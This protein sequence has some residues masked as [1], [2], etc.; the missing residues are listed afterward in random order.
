MKRLFLF[1]FTV[2]NTVLLSGMSID[3]EAAKEMATQFMNLKVG[4]DGH[5][6]HAPSRP[7][8]LKLAQKV[9][10]E[11]GDPLYY[12]FNLEENGYVIVSGNDVATPIL[13][14]SDEGSFDMN[15]IP[16][17]LKCLLNNY[18]NQIEFA[19]A[20]GVSK[21][22]QLNSDWD[23]ISPMIETKWNQGGPY[24][25]LCPI[26]PAY[27]KR[28]M[29]G[30]VGV[31]IGQLMYYHKWPKVG[32]GSVSYQWQNQTLS[33]DFSKVIFDW[34]DM[35]LS[36]NNAAYDSN[37]PV[38][39]LLYNC[40][41]AA[42]A[43]FG[44]EETDASYTLETLSDYFGYKDKIK[45]LSLEDTSVDDFEAVVYHEL[46]NSRP[47][48]F[49]AASVLLDSDDNQ[50]VGHAMVI[51]GFEDGYFHINFGWGGN[52]D[53]YFQLAAILVD[54][55]FFNSNQGILYDI[56]P[57]YNKAKPAVHIYPSSSYVL[58]ADGTE[59]I[60]WKGPESDINMT[61][62]DAF[63]NVKC[64]KG[65]AFMDISTVVDVVLPDNTEK[66][67]AKAFENCKELESVFIPQ[68]VIEIETEA[69]SNC[70][71]LDRIV[72]SY[73]STNF[74]SEK[75][76]LIDSNEKSVITCSSVLS[77]KVVIPEGIEKI[78]DY[79]FNNRLLTS[80]EFPESLTSIGDEAFMG[81]N[82]MSLVKLPASVNYVGSR[83]FM[84][85]VELRQMVVMASTPPQVGDAP[86]E[87]VDCSSVFLCVPSESLSLY[88][89]A[90]GWDQFSTLIGS[91][92]PE[93]KKLV[94]YMKDDSMTTFML[95]ETPLIK[96]NGT[97]LVILTSTTSITLNLAD[98]RKMQYY[99]E[100]EE[101][102]IP[103]KNEAYAVYNDGT[104]TFYFDKE[105]DSRE[106][107][108]FGLNSD[109]TDPAWFSVRN[110]VS[111]V[112]FNAS[113]VDARPTTTYQWFD[114]M[115]TLT[116]IEGMEYLNTSDVT[117]MAYMFHNCSALT[118]IDVSHFNTSK[119]RD[120]SHMFDYI[121]QVTS[122]DLRSFDTSNCEDMSNM[123]RNCFKLSKLDV[124]SF[125]TKNV[126]TM[127]HMF[128]G[129]Y[130]LTELD[131]SN[132]NTSKVTT[133]S[134]MFYLCSVLTLD[135]SSYDTSNVTD[136]G[137]M[138]GMCD[139]LSTLNIQNFNTA[140]VTN[141]DGMFYSCGK[142]T[143]LDVSMLNTSNCTNM[144]EM[145]KYCYMLQSLDVSN[146]DISNCNATQGMFAMNYGMQVFKISAS[147]T[148]LSEDAC[149]YIGINNDE[150]CTIIAPEGFDFGVDTS[151]EYFVWK[152]GK[153]KVGNTTFAVSSDY[154]DLQVGEK[155]TV[156]IKAGSGDYKLSNSRPDVVEAEISGESIIFTALS[157]GESTITITD[158][159]T[160][161]VA[162]VKVKVTAITSPTTI[163]IEPTSISF[164]TV[165]K[166]TTKTDYFT[167]YN[168][169]EGILTFHLE[170]STLDGIFNI[171][172]GSEEYVL[173]AGESKKFTVE[174]SVPIDYTYYGGSIAAYVCSDAS[175]A[176]NND[177]VMIG[178]STGEPAEETAY[179]VYNDGTL[180][181]YN[182][183][184]KD[185]REGNVYLLNTGY[186]YPQWQLSNDI[187]KVVFDS[188]FADARPTSTY[189]WFDGM[190]A[191]TEIEGM[192]Y[193]NTSEVT[194]M[195]Y[196][197]HNCSALT[198]IDVSHFNTSKVKDMSHMF[199]YIYQVTSLDLRSFDTSNCEDMSNMFENCFNLSK[200]DVSSF[201][202]ENVTT[203]SHMFDSCYPLSQLD[204]S[205]FNTSKVATMSWMFYHCGVLTLDLSSF[206]TSNVTDMEWMFG[207]CN[208]LTSLNIQNFNTANVTNMGGM[209]YDCDNLTIL[210]V[211]MLNTS[212]CTNMNEM[213][214]YCYKLQSLDV[215][216]FDI[217]NCYATQGMFI[218]NYGMQ[219]F[220][221][222]A[223][224]NNL[225]ED[226]CEHIGINNDE[227][228]TIIAPEGF[229]FGVDTSGDSFVWKSGTFR[230][231]VPTGM[232]SDFINFYQLPPNSYI[233]IFD[234]EGRM[235][236]N[237]R[238]GSTS[239]TLDLTS[240]GKGTF[241]VIVNGVTYK[242]VR[243]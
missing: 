153:F 199:D 10:S 101:P 43:N 173:D 120:M 163:K 15:N 49:D 102:I 121:Y 154:L 25:S 157:S 7:Q 126:T 81:C 138:F 106:G 113:F 40:A 1:L 205:N 147:M 204:L 9:L 200:L 111:K 234:I 19:S 68:S 22:K 170:Y 94:I 191:L 50:F 218:D 182:D 207:M 174:C 11:E 203:M 47:V 133:M 71:Y 39:E 32:T 3:E 110:D 165:T 63:D 228:C 64:I 185:S 74:I 242:I 180:T 87:G 198:S 89:T 77:G 26:D 6:Y 216:N 54:W 201:N 83:A 125:N 45:Y 129:C 192:E 189:Q 145:F 4:Q 162:T 135:L 221:I 151:G 38:A 168:T 184:E 95:S 140:N 236:R 21:A 197:F 31:A 231:P 97:E 70:P 128:D 178:F 124:S 34:D 144:N 167:V 35:E 122:L 88:Q 85:C 52:D 66:I 92:Q 175:N 243:K 115:S 130:T 137:W 127:S 99:E 196:M 76:L 105:K 181:F 166:G 5:S 91:S 90:S 59:L 44:Y 195:A 179:A 57:D 119:V 98:I 226:A 176:T 188:S 206:D 237:E 58:S 69:F 148:N 28:S 233:E 27:N 118:N 107:S 123:F 158:N 186:S 12:V 60:S 84:G 14:Y 160:Q 103:T 42:E 211:S 41:L 155:G 132:F 114:G 8:A 146:L 229:D 2:L 134:W 82:L 56:E 225:A 213:F 20:Q 150:I 193:L 209:F 210:D 79:A 208:E 232:I 172:G 164:G 238:T 65:H 220:K 33:A 46:A 149:E 214:K 222:S 109:G 51:D 96:N 240:L 215:S 227:I 100:S 136:M 36:Y 86:F 67:E 187:S 61:K 16:E 72:V 75:G 73:N 224:M 141:M 212:N 18:E 139:K 30:C 104:L 108:A 112:V 239:E 93:P 217:S 156:Q 235:I 219:M 116:E 190:S 29:V 169:G 152:S 117:N 37:N 241:V 161:Q 17:A 159:K 194:N 78:S 230:L 183:M 53:G 24:N 55:Y 143:S 48:I 202:T 13:G 80:I 171:V 131:V 62:D 177:A 23:D 142:L 223:S